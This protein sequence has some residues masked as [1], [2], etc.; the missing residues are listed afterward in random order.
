[1]Q[2]IDADLG[3]A[4]IPSAL[5]SRSR[6][7]FTISPQSPRPSAFMV[8]IVRCPSSRSRLR[9]ML[10]RGTTTALAVALMAAPCALRAAAQH[11]AGEAAAEEP[12]SDPA[13]TEADAGTEPAPERERVRFDL[14]AG[15]ALPVHLGVQ[16]LLELPHRIQLAAEVGW[17][18]RSYVE[19]IN[20]VCTGFGWYD[21]AT[22][23]LIGAALDN[24][25]VLRA[26]AGWRPFPSEGF[27]VRVGYTAALLGGGLSATEA[28][29]AVTGREL[30]TS[31]TEVPLQATAHAF[32]VAL[33]W[34]FFIERAVLL[35]L[36][37]SY[38]QIFYTDA[39]IA[40]D[41]S[42]GD[43]AIAAAS[44]ALGT[45]LDD[46]LGTFAKTPTLSAFV[47][48]RFE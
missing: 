18:P 45:Y 42:R 41:P 37:V 46:V 6:V 33:S 8:R 39:W 23:A 17:M 25:L 11:P 26:A 32:Q 14:A 21:D 43:A 22:A 30:R 19:L 1:M 4:E 16:A 28:V 12:A 48:Y 29:E 47:G 24:A 13:A 36:E 44:E 40:L 35:R 5:L 15:T 38:F 7:T 10:Q 34:A 2:G 31:G 9:P 3:G 20:E 27:E